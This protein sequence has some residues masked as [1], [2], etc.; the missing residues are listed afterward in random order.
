MISLSWNA[1]L[2]DPARLGSALP[3]AQ[4]IK[5]GLLQ[6]DD[7]IYSGCTWPRSGS[8]LPVL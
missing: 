2:S 7:G 1:V 4:T 3:L 6:R 8:C 5:I